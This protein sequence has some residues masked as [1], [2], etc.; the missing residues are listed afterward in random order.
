MLNHVDRVGAGNERLRQGGGSLPHAQ[1]KR[2]NLL[3]DHL[4]LHWSDPCGGPL[5]KSDSRTRHDDNQN[6]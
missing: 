5:T 3:L 2:L 4:G 6:H 1:V